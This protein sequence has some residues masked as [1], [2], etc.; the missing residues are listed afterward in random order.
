MDFVYTK[1]QTPRGARPDA[2][3]SGKLYLIKNVSELRLTYQ[4][5][6]LAFMAKTKGKKLIVQLPKGAKVHESLRDFVREMSGLVKIER[7]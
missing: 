1:H 6:L 3:V 2:D 7:A 5:K 4:I